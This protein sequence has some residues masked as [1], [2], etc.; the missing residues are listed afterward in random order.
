MSLQGL[1]RYAPFAFGCIRAS[2][3]LST[4]VTDDVEYS[5]R[6]SVAAFFIPVVN[7]IRPYKVV[8]EVYELSH[9][10]VHG[11]PLIALWW[12]LFL[13]WVFGTLFGPDPDLTRSGDVVLR[14]WLAIIADASGVGAGIILITLLTRIT[15]WQDHSAEA[16]AMRPSPPQAEE[17]IRVR[18]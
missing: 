17:S 11:S 12:T 13:I 8:R 15:S 6:S 5:P 9:P 10:S 16:S 2:K 1:Y 4:L 14:Y 3:N 18:R 7:L